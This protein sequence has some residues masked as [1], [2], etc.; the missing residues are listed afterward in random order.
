MRSR[1]S[2][3]L[4]VLEHLF[5]ICVYLYN[6]YNAN[7]GIAYNDFRIKGSESG[8]STKDTGK[9]PTLEVHFKNTEN[10]LLKKINLYIKK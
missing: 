8:I 7:I 4:F 3:K 5:P 10:Q 1:G 9:F 2:L 6:F